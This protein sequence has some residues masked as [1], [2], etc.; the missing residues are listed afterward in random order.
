MSIVVLISTLVIVRAFRAYLMYKVLDNYLRVEYSMAYTNWKALKGAG[1]TISTN[2][3][4]GNSQTELIRQEKEAIKFE[5][6][7]ALKY[8]EL[9]EFWQTYGPWADIVMI[10]TTVCVCSG[11]LMCFRKFKSNLQKFETSPFNPANGVN[12]TT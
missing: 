8:E 4:A 2:N 10:M 7:E 9:E 12:L 3:K 6:D 11:V 5:Y 1:V